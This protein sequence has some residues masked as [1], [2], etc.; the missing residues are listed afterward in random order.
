M[1]TGTTRLQNQGEGAITCVGTANPKIF[2]NNFIA[3]T[4]AI[5]SFSSIYIDARNNWWGASPPDLKIFWGESI[6]IKPWLKK[7]NPDAFKESP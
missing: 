6:N 7:E 4:V 2:Q 5:Q 1:I 3:N